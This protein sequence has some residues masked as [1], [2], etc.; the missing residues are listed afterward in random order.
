[1]RVRSFLLLFS[2]LLSLYSLQAASA[3]DSKAILSRADQFLLKH[4]AELEGFYDDATRI[5]FHI[6]PLDSR[7]AMAD[8]PKP[9]DA[10]LK[11]QN[12]IGN[13]NLK[14][15]CPEGRPW[16]LYVQAKVS[17]YRSVVTSVMPIAKGTIIND[18]HLEMREVDTSKLNG[19][20]FIS[21]DEVINMQASRNLRADK[22]IVAYH[23][24]LPIVIKK[25]DAVLMTA[26]GKGLLVKIPG[27]A[28]MDGR[29]G[30]Q[31][32]V[33]NNQSKRTVEAKVSGPGQVMITM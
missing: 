24:S 14:I 33:R 25:G 17:L 6:S 30:Q 15:S 4:V 12:T 31:I 19:S 29:K 32:S 1:M 3:T 23:L 26:Q 2:V 18:G 21:F 9:L 10:K 8:C 11:S 27:Q 22:V 20:Y 13:I 5:E 28:L 16:S 7:L